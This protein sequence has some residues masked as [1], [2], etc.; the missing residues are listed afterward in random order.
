MSF[1]ISLLTWSATDCQFPSAGWGVMFWSPFP[2]SQTI[3]KCTVILCNMAQCK[4]SIFDSVYR[5]SLCEKQVVGRLQYAFFFYSVGAIREHP[6]ETL[7]SPAGSAQRIADAIRQW[8]QQVA[9]PYKPQSTL[10][11]TDKRCNPACMD[12]PPTLRMCHRGVFIRDRR[13]R[14]AEPVPSSAI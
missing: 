2:M 5:S 14:I 10:R 9:L 6:R 1:A 12:S 13:V 7:P 11:E 3:P 8:F 4:R